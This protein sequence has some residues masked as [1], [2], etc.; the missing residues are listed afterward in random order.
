MAVEVIG[1]DKHTVK[2]ERIFGL[3]KILEYF[4]PDYDPFA[5][6]IDVQ[7]GIELVAELDKLIEEVYGLSGRALIQKRIEISVSNNRRD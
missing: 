1:Q 5:G 6:G 3:V 2:E 4:S 7:S